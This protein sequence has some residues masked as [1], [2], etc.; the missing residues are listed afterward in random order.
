MSQ[1]KVMYD[2]R[3]ASHNRII[4]GNQAIANGF[5]DQ[6]AARMQVREIKSRIVVFATLGSWTRTERA[7]NSDY[8]LLLIC[9]DRQTLEHVA[10]T[11]AD[12]QK[13]L[14]KETG[15]VVTV[16]TSFRME[17]LHRALVKEPNCLIHLLM[18][19]SKEDF[20]C[21]ERPRVIRSICESV[22][23]I[24]GDKK[25][26]S[27]IAQDLPP[28]DDDSNFDDLS[29]LLYNSYIYLVDGQLMNKEISAREGFHKLQYVVRHIT[30]ESLQKLGIKADSW[31]SVAE[32]H[33]RLGLKSSSIVDS[34]YGIRAL[35]EVSGKFPIG[36]KDLAELFEM[37]FQFLEDVKSL[38]SRFWH[39]V[40]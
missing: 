25:L 13:Q 26:L 22:Q 33:T 19:P 36:C 27:Q 29:C 37:A 28:E 23:V 10:W 15:T 38:R 32:Q 2:C 31:R 16:F 5:I 39:V 18:Y 8:D 40:I 34:I 9:K 24:I 1:Q 3:K 11:V 21:W 20:S 12:I 17:E 6:L 35:N 7:Y 30:A 14:L 4:R